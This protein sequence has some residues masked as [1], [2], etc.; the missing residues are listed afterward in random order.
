[1]FIY[2]D[3]IFRTSDGK[4]YTSEYLKN[5]GKL[6]M[7]EQK[8]FYTEGSETVEMFPDDDIIYDYDSGEV[9]RCMYSQFFDDESDSVIPCS[10][11]VLDDENLRLENGSVDTS[12]FDEIYQIYIYQ[13]YIIDANFASRLITHTNE[14]V[15]YHTKL[16]VYILGV[17][18]IGTKWSHVDAEYIM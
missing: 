5:H 11:A 18:H 3:S 2:C 13:M 9:I 10:M 15:F 8:Y 4:Y 12:D 17:T 14:L 1:M 7:E 16:D 6:F